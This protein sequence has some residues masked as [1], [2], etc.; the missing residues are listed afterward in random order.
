MRRYLYTIIVCCSVT[1]LLILLHSKWL[2]NRQSTGP[3]L[4][5]LE[6]LHNKEPVLQNT[7]SRSTATRDVTHNGIL[8]LA[9][10]STVDSSTPGPQL[11]SAYYDDRPGV[12]GRP[13]VV[14]LGYQLR[15]HIVNTTLYCLL[16]YSSQT[17]LCQRTP[18]AKF[19]IANGNPFLR[20]KQSEA[21]EYACPSSPNIPVKVALSSS[22]NC[23]NASEGIAVD[24]HRLKTM[25]EFAVCVQSPV[26]RT[27]SIRIAEF[28][29]MQL[30]LGAQYIV[31]YLIE[32]PKK[33]ERLKKY[34]ERGQLVM[35]K[36]RPIEL[37]YN[38]Q[39]LLMQDCLYSNMNRVKYLVFVDIDELIL[40]IQHM[41]WTSMMKTI[42]TS[43][44]MGVFVF[45]NTY[46]TKNPSSTDLSKPACKELD[47]PIY[48]T[49]T[50]RYLCKYGLHRRSKF[51]AK[52]S[53]VI[54]LGIHGA[55]IFR[56][57]HSEV[58]VPN[59]VGI[60][61][62]YRF[63]R[64][65]DCTNTSTVLDTTAMRYYSHVMK[66]LEHAICSSSPLAAAHHTS[67]TGTGNKI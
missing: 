16:T 47:L 37:H 39:L 57:H 31:I 19:I 21:M 15:V 28:I 46:F 34:S 35:V 12:P 55:S 25:H 33:L 14:V 10:T 64:T 52:P 24:N 42:D 1:I 50:R 40:P 65:S 4:S 32:I 9:W 58:T 44:K 11:L 22:P 41:N 8:H 43:P 3:G 18:A 7:S 61:A 2:P 45:L 62:H 53:T 36:W 13:A 38:G 59:T 54:E 60:N 63:R 48:F 30:I 27:S 56:G 20:N 51:I 67:N 66:S 29:E 5:P 17:T 26:F 6:P 49:W 23:S